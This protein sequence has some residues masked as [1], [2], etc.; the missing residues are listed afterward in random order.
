[1]ETSLH[2]FPNAPPRD[3]FRRRRQKR[4]TPPPEIDTIIANT[5]CSIYRIDASLLHG[6]SRGSANVAL[7][8]QVAMYLAH[9]VG[10][11]DYTGVG[12]LYGRDRTTVKYACAVVEDMRDDPAF[13]L[14]IHLLER[15]V[16]RTC[17]L[18]IGRGEEVVH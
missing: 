2:Q 15:I 13:D 4:R 3:W 18:T 14:T 6:T 10:R 12:R 8:R 17:W 1:M 11:L 5:I 7:A 9:V 16:E